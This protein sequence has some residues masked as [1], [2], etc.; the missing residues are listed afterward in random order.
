MIPGARFLVSGRSRAHFRKET[1]PE[2]PLVP[3]YN[4][5]ILGFQ[6]LGIGRAG[7]CIPAA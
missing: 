6:L 5:I 4:I 7:D 2:I 3:V 1:A